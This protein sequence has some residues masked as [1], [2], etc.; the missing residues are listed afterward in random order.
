MCGITGKIYFENN[1]QTVSQN[2]IEKMNTAIAHRG[3]DDSDIYISPNQKMGLGHQR[4]S[5]IDLSPLGHQPMH[6][7]HNGKKYTIVFNGE[8]YNFQAE[9][10]ELKKENYQFKS[11]TDTEVIMA[12]Y[13]KYGIGFLKHL[14][15]M[16]VLALHDHQKIVGCPC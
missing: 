7:Q 15:G 12:L 4:L 11:Q 10:A 6:Y 8:I 3:P 5:I 1:S 9:R 16:F 14:R 2:D 13:D